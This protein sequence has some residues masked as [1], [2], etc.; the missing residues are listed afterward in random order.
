MKLN[1][2]LLFSCVFEYIPFYRPENY[3]NSIKKKIFITII[4]YLIKNI[5]LG[6]PL[7]CIEA[8]VSLKI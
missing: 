8:Y 3:A 7:K 4:I 6:N 2:F 5:Y 1:T